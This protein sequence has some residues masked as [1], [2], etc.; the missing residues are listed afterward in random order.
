MW[1][2]SL[3][4]CGRASQTALCEASEFKRSPIVQNRFV[5]TRVARDD[6]LNATLDFCQNMEFTDGLLRTPSSMKPPPQQPPPKPT[7]RTRVFAL[8]LRHLEACGMR[9]L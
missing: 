5:R 9:I 1:A 7:L 2:G 6:S 3:V 4:N 8:G